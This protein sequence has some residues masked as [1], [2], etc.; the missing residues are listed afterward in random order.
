MALRLLWYPAEAIALTPPPELSGFVVD[1][2]LR[3]LWTKLFGHCPSTPISDIIS[4]DHAAQQLHW[5]MDLALAKTFKPRRAPDPWGVCWWNP[6]CD[7]ALHAIHSSHSETQKTAVR[8][9]RC[10]IATSKCN[11][12]HT[13][14]YY[15]TSDKLWEATAWH[16]GCSIKR[17]PPLLVTPSRLSDDIS[18]MTQAFRDHFFITDH[19]DVNPFQTEDPPPLAPHD[20]API[21]QS[22]ISTALTPTSNKSAPGLS[23]IGYQLLKWAFASRPNR[24]MEIFNAAITLGHHPWSDALVVVIPKPAKPDYSLP[25]AYHPIS[26]LECCGKLLEKIIAK[27]ILSDIHFYDILSP[28][29]FGSCDYHCAVNAA[30]CLVHNAQATVWASLVASVVLFDISGFFDNINILRTIHIFRNLGFP[31]LLCT[32]V[33]SFLSHRNIRLS[34]NGLKSEP[35]HLNHGTPQGSLLSPILSAIYTSPLL[36]FINSTWSRRGLNMYIDDGTIF[37]NAKNHQ[38]SALNTTKGLQEIMAWLGRNSLKCDEDKTEFISFSPPHATEH[39]IGRTVTSIHPC[40]SASTSYTVECSSLICYL[41]IF[42]HERFDWTHH[43]TIMANHACSTVRALSILRNSIHSLDYANWHKLFHTL[44]LPVLTYGFPLYS[45]QPHN[46]GLLNILQVA[47]NDMV[48]KMSGAFKM[49]PIVP[50]HYMMAIPPLPLTIT[51][52]TLNF[53]LHLQRLPPSTLLCTITLSNPAADWHLSLNPPTALTRLLP[54]AYPTFFFPAPLYDTTWT[55]PQFCDHLAY[56]LTSDTKEAT[57]LLIL[58]PPPH[59]FHLFI[60]ILMIPSPPFAASFLL[61]KGQTLV[62]SGAVWDPSCLRALFMALCNGLTYASLSNHI[63]IFL[64]DLSLSP[65]LFLFHKHPL[66]DLSHAFQS[67][68]TAFFDANPCHHTDAYRYSIKWSRLPGM[69]RIDSLLEEQQHI[70]FPLPPPSLITPKAQLLLDWQ[71][72]YDLLR[73]D[74]RYWQSIICPDSEPPPFY[75]G[76][77]SRLDHRTTSSAVQLAFDHAFTATYS[78]LFRSHTG[79]NTL[80]PEHTHHIMPPSPITEQQHFDCLMCDFHDPRSHRPPSLSPSPHSSWASLPRPQQLS[81]GGIWQRLSPGHTQWRNTTDHILFRCS[82]L[83]SPCCWFFG[84]SAFDAY[85][86]G[87][88]DGGIKLGNFQRATNWLLRPLPPCPDPSWLV[89]A[90]WWSGSAS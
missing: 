65:Y 19:P 7:V 71:N 18:E 14:L 59:T 70:I 9:L 76:A 50:L 16:K 67:L 6:D 43:V 51:K 69:A 90:E 2:L 79:D 89:S 28:T 34:F 26:L 21:T 88:F 47:Q 41:G 13:F 42:I 63:H 33:E 3:D 60:H 23:S 4:L 83:S 22:E 53:R 77:L 27:C 38:L 46:K 49:T 66:L 24:F 37:S 11:W 74:A 73:H 45:T 36:K 87:T 29:Q 75:K 40:T 1:E 52:L 31:P 44:I 25:K 78:D 30:L 39:L 12:S 85:V 72:A 86:F 54:D 61:F 35:I 58:Q 62:H 80:C 20:L 64:P 32:W 81:P 10:T 48:H 5:D 17:I 15:T 8:H 82:P 84:T 57:K 68:L 55:H 56:K